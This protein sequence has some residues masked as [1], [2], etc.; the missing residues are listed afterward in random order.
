MKNKIFKI[1][2]TVFIRGLGAASQVVAFFT[3]ARVYDPSDAALIYFYLA[4]LTISTPIVLLG[5]NTFAV[6]FVART[7]DQIAIE[8]WI[9][10]SSGFLIKRC[11]PI[12]IIAP[13]PLYATGRIELLDVLIIYITLLVVPSFN[14]FA[15]VLQGFK[16]FNISIFISNICNYLLLSITLY[17]ANLDISPLQQLE[18]KVVFAIC[19]TTSSTLTLFVALIIVY[20]SFSGISLKPIFHATSSDVFQEENRSEVFRFWIIYSL[21]VSSA[22]LPQAAF[23]FFGKNDEFAFFSIS[24]RIANTVIFFN[25][26]ATFM[27][28]PYAS[29]MHSTGKI[30]EL[31]NLFFRLSIITTL[32]VL[33]ISAF[34]LIFPEAVL[35]LFG[36]EYRSGALYLQIMVISQLINVATGSS[37]TI[38]I[39]T[40]NARRLL[41]SLIYSFSVGSVITII[42]G[43]KLGGV[44]FA[45]GFACILLIQNVLTFY[46][47]VHKVLKMVPPPIKTE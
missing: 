24:Q 15:F 39:M 20:K 31:R 47:V 6:K 44:G 35:S 4:A 28:G 12:I 30:K 43:I 17:L 33:P 8:K 21:V 9:R 2:T 25:M 11:S 13:V 37:N 3:V 32:A 46:F 14:F 5:F 45:L 40:G 16:K 34:Y 19:L 42:L 23:Y 38:L 10:T 29:E 27:L 1:L 18:S 36:E 26:V 41:K 7:T 22:W